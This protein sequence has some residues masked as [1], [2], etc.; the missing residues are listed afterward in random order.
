MIM[1]IISKGVDQVDGF[2]T[3]CNI[4]EVTREKH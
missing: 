3:G 4:F 2:I 1:K